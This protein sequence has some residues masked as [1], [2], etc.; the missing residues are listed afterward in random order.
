MEDAVAPLE[1]WWGDMAVDKDGN[2]LEDPNSVV[3]F[4]G[5]LAAPLKN[6]NMKDLAEFFLENVAV[7]M[8]PTTIA[9]ELKAKKDEKQYFIKDVDGTWGEEG[10]D[11]TKFEPLVKAK[12]ANFY[13]QRVDIEATKLMTAPRIEVMTP[14]F[15]P[16]V[17]T[18]RVVP[19]DDNI[20]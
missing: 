7:M 18:M 2:E 6:K 17:L 5:C 20:R 14:L 15:E 4:K 11:Y 8:T 16:A 10:K 1:E 19:P 9:E 13:K 3:F 12:F